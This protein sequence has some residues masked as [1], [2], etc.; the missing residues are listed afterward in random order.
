MARSHLTATS[1]SWVQAILPAPA[2]QVAGTT[3][4]HHHIQLIFC[5]F[6]RD[7]ALPCWPGWSRTPD[8]R[9]SARLDLPK[10]WDYRR[11][12]PCLAEIFLKN[13]TFFSSFNTEYL[14][15]EFSKSTLSKPKQEE[16]GNILEE[17]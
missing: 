17:T 15:Y 12:P 10:C 7:G 13:K 1:I 6:I 3:G 11:E 14:S 2:S 8:L 9:R 16:V 5:I 4:A